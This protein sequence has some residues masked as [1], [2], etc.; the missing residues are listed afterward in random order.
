MWRL[1]SFSMLIALSAC[2]P[3]T[4]YT[5]AAVGQLSLLWHRQSVESLLQDEDLPTTQR[6]SLELIAQARQFAV[7]DLHLPDNGSYTSYV[8]VDREH[9]VWNV[10]AAPADSTDPLQW[11][12]PIAGCVTYRGYFSAD[13]AAR[14][15]D[16]LERRGFDVYVAGVDAYSTLGWFRDPIPSTIMQRPAHRLAGLIFHELAHQR[17]YA[18]NDTRFNESFASFVEQEGLRRWLS[19]KGDSDTFERYRREQ[20]QQLVF[21]SFVAEWRDRFEELYRQSPDDVKQQKTRLQDQMR[22]EWLSRDDGAGYRGWFSGPLNNAQLATVSSYYDWV[23]AFEVLY[24]QLDGKL[25]PFYDQVQ[26]LADAEPPERQQRLQALLE[27]SFS[28]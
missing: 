5:Q 7:Y 15:A 2:T 17:V 3:V 26:Q 19:A 20:A 4:F 13:A 8:D 14:Y 23:P 16:S 9:L 27:Q 25:Q 21:T 11:C 24:Q 18:A 6:Q 1:A 10:F 22:A 12:F 28:H